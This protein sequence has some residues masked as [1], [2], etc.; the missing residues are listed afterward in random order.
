VDNAPSALIER[1]FDPESLHATSYVNEVLYSA[2][3]WAQDT[4]SIPANATIVTFIV[5]PAQETS[6]VANAAYPDS[7]FFPG[8]FFTGLT[9]DDVGGLRY[10][11]GTNNL[12]F[13]TLL[14]DVHAAPSSTNPVVNGAIRPGVDKL[15]FVRHPFDSQRGVF[16]TFTNQFLDRYILNGQLQQQQLQRVLDHPDFLF[17]AG[18]NGSFGPMVLRTG[19]TGWINNATGNGNSGGTGP[20]VISPPVVIT[21]DRHGDQVVT[22]ESYIFDPVSSSWGSFDGT[23]NARVAYPTQAPANANPLVVRFLLLS[24]VE[25]A[26]PL[27]TFEWQLPIPYGAA[28]LLQTATNLSDWVSVC[29]A[30]NKGSA[31]DWEHSGASQSQAQRFFRVVP[32]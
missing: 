4:N 5:D 7:T 3:V 25:Y 21:F 6:G 23:T 24:G 32:Q 27:Q 17:A 11:F 20:G 9:Y 18:D 10:L 22:T 14:P 8:K 29:I 26:K 19:T 1:N 30:T 28:A 13:E 16:L 2:Y 12:A 15:T 31:F